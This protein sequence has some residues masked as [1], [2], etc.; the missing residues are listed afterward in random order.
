MYTRSLHVYNWGVVYMSE[1]REMLSARIP[2][3][4]KDLVDADGRSNQEVVRAAL[5]REFGGKRVGDLERRIKEKERR[6]SI[7]KEER[8]RRESELSELQKE[9]NALEEKYDKKK[10]RE[11]SQLEEAREALKDAPQEPENPAV[12]HWADKLDLEPGELLDKLGGDD[13]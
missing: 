12:Q 13:A 4:L 5:W 9:L 10:E 8:E 7:V 3:E 6:I 2:S 1:E 11:Q